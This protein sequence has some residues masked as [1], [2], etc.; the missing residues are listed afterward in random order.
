MT[1]AALLRLLDEIDAQGGPDAA[2][3]GRLHQPD[4]QE[5]DMPQPVPQ[6]G[7]ARATPATSTPPG[8]SVGQLLAWADGH[9]DAEVQVEAARARALLTG[10]RARHAA[11]EELTAITT[12]A[13]QLEERLAQLHARQAEL[14]PK[15]GSAKRP[16]YPAREVR[17]WAKE[18]GVACPAVGRVPAAVV[19]A[20]RK[21][22]RPTTTRP[23]ED[24]R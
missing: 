18:H 24:R 21:A 10:L 12:E 8:L 5:P 2:R 16:A 7:P 17:A 11:D 15:K 14:A 9:D 4:H 20:W 13:E 6:P 23:T 1:I 22:T 19:D 3:Q